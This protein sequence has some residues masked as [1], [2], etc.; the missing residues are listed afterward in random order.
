MRKFYNCIDNHAHSYFG[1]DLNPMRYTGIFM[2]RKTKGFSSSKH[3]DIHPVNRGENKRI[4]NFHLV[5]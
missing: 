5:K 2:L 1:E 3:K 4:L